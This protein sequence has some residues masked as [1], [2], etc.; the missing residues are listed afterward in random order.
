MIEIMVWRR[1]YVIEIMARQGDEPKIGFD[2]IM[3]NVKEGLGELATLSSK[4]DFRRPTGQAK[5]MV[6]CSIDNDWLVCVEKQ[7]PA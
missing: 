3:G 5:K 7:E 4:T 6:L 2:R 1:N